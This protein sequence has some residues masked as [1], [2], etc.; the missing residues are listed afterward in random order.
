MI[1]RESLTRTFSGP[2]ILRLEVRPDGVAIVTIDDPGAP[3][4]TI[5]EAFAQQ[6]E[7]VVDRILRDGDIL[8]AVCVSGKADSF[9]VGADLDAVRRIRFAVDGERR[10]RRLAESIGR[11]GS[12]GKP[13]VAAVHGAAL[14]AGFELALACS[15]VVVSDDAATEIGLPEV[16]LGLLPAANGLLRVAERA[17]LRVAL[18]LGLSGKSE[19]GN[20]ALS[21]GLVDDVCARSVLVDVAAARALALRAPGSK[22]RARAVRPAA[23]PLAIR[24]ALEESMVGRKILLFEA[25]AAARVRTQGHYPAPQRIVD[26]L[27]QFGRRGFRAAADLEAKAFGD[28]VVTETSRRLVELFFA[29]TAL[30]RDRGTDDASAVARPSD[31]VVV[32]GGGLMGGGIAAITIQAGV[33]VRV[34]EVD[35]IALGRALA[36]VGDILDER[37]ARRRMT[38]E[39]R[40][41][42]LARLTA[43]TDYSGIS[44]ADVVIEAVYED[45]ALKQRVL[46]DVEARVP[47]TTVIASCTSCI[48]IGMIAEASRCP[49]RVVGMHYF[50]PVHK[51]PLL[52]V[53]RTDRAAPSALATAVALGKRQGKTV[54]V[55]RDGVGFY[56]SRV[57]V[58]YLREA[59]FL[60]SEGASVDAVDAAIVAWGWPIGALQLL[61]EIGIDVA[62]RVGKIVHETFGERIAPPVSLE[63]LTKDG[64]MGRKN[65]RG[66]YLYDARARARGRPVVD[67]GVY[68]ALRVSPGL[69]LPMEE[70]QMRC[71]LQLVNEALRCFGEGTVRSPRD[72]DVGAIFGLGFPPFRG[73]PFRYVDA[74]G[75]AEV[76]RRV[77][78]YEDRFGARWTP[79]PV[80]VERA[81]SGSRFYD[82]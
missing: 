81:S 26:V 50:T 10:A 30:K 56:T 33:P 9:V 71:V 75:P 62:A 64:R 42:I 55:V 2:A 15:A 13:V 44:R 58:P 7:G 17:G 78:G 63:T 38:R 68:A 14:G 77:R 3:H 49:S 60:V 53:I 66:F 51:M 79:A 69:R 20:K 32:I 80:L 6:L 59:L 24:R 67:A 11:L 18:Q 48:P 5:T 4:N 8:G 28:L 46:R 31:R 65:G 36:C 23:A 12:L 61:D 29:T 47:E 21:L 39:D 34:K 52:E 73:G 82:D 41:E 16:Q 70:I 43:T 37:V 76:L 57:L 27:A 19:R 22:G 25:R 72:G 35:D 74:V 40:G 45:L 1:S 54:I